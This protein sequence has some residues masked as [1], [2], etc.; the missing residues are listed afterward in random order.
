MMYCGAEPQPEEPAQEATAL[1]ILAEEE[2]DGSR[3]TARRLQ[4]FEQPISTLE[5]S[6]Q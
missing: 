5:Q 3:T 1:T 4:P 6:S 2:D